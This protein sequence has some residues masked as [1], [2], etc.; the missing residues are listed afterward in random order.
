MYG[1]IMEKQELDH[2]SGLYPIRTVAQLTGVN[3]VT[4]RA[5]ER[6]YR[7]I[8]PVRTPKGHRLYSQQHIEQIRKVLRLLEQG[9]S[10]G[11]VSHL[12]QQDT[13]SP[14][15]TR[16]A[17]AGESGTIWLQYQQRMLEAVYAFDER[18][19]DAIYNDVLSLYPVDLV[20]SR[21][22]TP[23]L[24]QIGACWDDREN[25][26]AEEH[27]FS[28]YLRNKIGSR[29]QHNI[30]RSNGPCL[31]TACLPGEQH[32]IGLLLFVLSAISAGYRCIILGANM[33]MEQ[34]PAIQDKHHIDAIVLSGSVEPVGGKTGKQLKQL[35]NSVEI[36]VFVGGNS[37]EQH[38]KAIESAGAIPLGAEIQTALSRL[39]TKLYS[40]P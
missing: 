37:S 3:P 14:Q 24:Q 23:L 38:H 21:L 29:I 9:I 11:Q 5:W 26:I 1:D 33:P 25:G 10:I 2:D 13:I 8:R 17:D 34:L 27:F 18:R 6:R 30:L 20:T 35:V 16:S 32:E 39:S 40:T 28:V 7:L 31:L 4:L 15:V 19:L 22:T 12:L 36:P